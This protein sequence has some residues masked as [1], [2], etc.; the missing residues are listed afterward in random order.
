LV[1][2]DAADEIVDGATYCKPGDY[3]LGG[4]A[5]ATGHS[6]ASDQRLSVGEMRPVGAPETRDGRHG[7]VAYAQEIPPGTSSDWV[8]TVYAVCASE[9]VPGH[10]MAVA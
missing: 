5:H 3:V 9:P 2:D 8:L 4:G 1:N 7:F 10:R 6:L